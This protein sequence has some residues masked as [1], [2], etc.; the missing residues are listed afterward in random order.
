MG[1]DNAE[2]DKYISDLGDI[3][4]NDTGTDTQDN[5]NG[6]NDTVDNASADA[7]AQSESVRRDEQVG[8]EQSD[9]N[10]PVQPQGKQP[11]QGTQAPT[12]KQPRPLGDGTFMDANGNIT[13][14]N[15]Q[16]I[17]EK[18]FASRMYQQNQRLKE[19]NTQLNRQ[20]EE[21]IPRV[22][23][24]EVLD[25]N[26]KQYGLDTME[27]A[28]ALDLAGRMKRGDYLGVAKEVIA[29]VMAQGYNATDLLGTE[30]GDT[31]EMRS[32]RQMLDERLAPLQREEQA[33]QQNEQATQRAQRAYAEFVSNND[34]AEVH[35]NDIAS[36]ARQHGIPVQQAYN[37]VRAFA[38]DNGFDFS[39][40]LKPQIEARIA[41][42]ETQS[43]ANQQRQQPTRP[44]PNGASTRMNGEPQNIAPASADDDWGTILRSVM[45]TM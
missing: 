36:V 39:K 40:P 26:I 1:N 18:G 14:E 2:L 19:Q 23:E 11:K 7:G 34:Y 43:P 12:G 16:I 10:T 24:L 8:A 17:A 28:Q 29:L 21:I 42:H 45:Q 5:S 32:V 15:G 22:R 25:R 41:E 37:R 33:R 13:T 44:M 4:D 3:D 27:T 20:F 9:K 38:F 31:L 6:G 35:A 30:V